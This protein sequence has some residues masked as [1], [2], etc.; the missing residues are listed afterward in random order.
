MAR[1]SLAYE[2][3]NE[4]PWGHA[5]VI[6]V[7]VKRSC[8]NC[9]GISSPNSS[10][11]RTSEPVRGKR[12]PPRRGGAAGSRRRDRRR[13]VAERARQAA[14]RRQAAFALDDKLADEL[15]DKATRPSTKPST[16]YHFTSCSTASS[17]RRP[18]PHRRDDVGD[19]LCRRP[20]RDELEDNLLWRAGDFLGVSA[21][22]RIVLRRR[23]VGEDADPASRAAAHEPRRADYRCI[24]GHRCR[25]LRA[26]SPPR[27]ESS[28]WRGARTVSRAGRQI[29]AAAHAPDSCWPGSRTRD[30]VSAI[31]AELT[32]RGLEPAF[33]VNNA[34]SDL[35]G[36]GRS[37]P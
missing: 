8:L 12:L 35:S 9:S 10:T 13:D 4:R 37:R 27:H 6:W 17:T 18:R 22:E 5:K 19:R 7:T 16:P 2:R 24:G 32:A 3:G 14:I 26:S 31:A 20:K 15:I 1:V 23:I 36:R 29:A 25:S 30:A 21:Q 11:A 34:G 33:V 28:W